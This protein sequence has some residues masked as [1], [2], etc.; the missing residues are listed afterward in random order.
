MISNRERKYI[1]SLQIKKYRQQHQ[2]FLVEGWKSVNELIQSNFE[3]EMLFISE[4]YESQCDGRVVDEKDIKSISSMMNNNEAIAVAKMP[5]KK[6]SIDQT[7][8]IFIFDSIQDPGNL[9]TIVRT[10]DWLGFT[11]V[12]CSKDSVDFYNSK[13]ISATKGSF[14]RIQP[15]YVDL[16]DFKPLTETGRN[17]L[18][19]H[20]EG[21]S[22]KDVEIDENTIVIFG[23]ESLGHSETNLEKFKGR[24]TIP[25]RGEAE[26]LNLAM[27]FGII[28]SSI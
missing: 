9:G 26:S 3:I 8:P 18:L 22:Y 4:R 23:N 14:L 1:K 10:A 7:Q 21:K 15:T 20:M 11:N 12:V 2:A 13:V 24:I 16:N 28:A 5:H 27:S 19:A 25:K 17:V 6:A